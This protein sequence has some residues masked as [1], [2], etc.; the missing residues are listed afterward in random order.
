MDSYQYILESLTGK[1]RSRGYITDEDI[2]DALP[3]EDLT[4]EQLDDLLETLIASN[5]VIVETEPHKVW[6]RPPGHPSPEARINELMERI[7]ERERA[8]H[9]ILFRMPLAVAEGFKTIK[10]KDG[11]NAASDPNF[12]RIMSAYRKSPADP[13]HV[14]A[15]ANYLREAGLAREDTWQI[16]SDVSAA[17][18]EL[19]HAAGDEKKQELASSFD[20]S[21]ED[22]LDSLAL[23]KDQQRVINKIRENICRE[24]AP[25]MVKIC[26]GGGDDDKRQ[27]GFI[28]L[29]EAMDC[30]SYNQTDFLA[31]ATDKI[32][33]SLFAMRAHNSEQCDESERLA[34]ITKFES[35]VPAEEQTA[36]E[37]TF[38]DVPHTPH[39]AADPRG[40]FSGIDKIT[41]T[42]VSDS[43]LLVKNKPFYQRAARELVKTMD[44]RALLAES[45]SGSEGG[46]EL[47]GMTA[48]GRAQV[49]AGRRL[50][51]RARIVGLRAEA[52]VIKH[53]LGTLSE[54]EYQSLCWVSREGITP[55]WDIEYVAASGQPVKIEVKGTEGKM[56]PNID[57]SGNEWKAAEEQ[58]TSY[59]LYIVTECISSN[60][61]IAKINDPYAMAENGRIRAFPL[62]WRLEMLPECPATE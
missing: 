24:Y 51:A 33:A 36:K 5:V 14:R 10:E 59:W 12:I 37:R 49:D 48:A 40:M 31:F 55:G 28:A 30:Y 56:F 21:P 45:A 52:F 3:T 13:H 35:L 16:Y 32:R 17:L 38:V 50:S 26:P 1:G 9:E 54:E 60:P 43:R 25:I 57:I 39:P 8:V 29:L 53:L 47:Q 46:K 7:L 15:I 20:A 11:S 42:V 62:I 6:P 44:V 19:R 22:A 2:N 58:R 23:I 34:P 27:D 61:Q 4:V 18:D 41:P